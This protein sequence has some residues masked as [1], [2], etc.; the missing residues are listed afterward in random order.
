MEYTISRRVMVTY[1]RAP[2]IWWYSEGSIKRSPSNF[3]IFDPEMQ[4]AL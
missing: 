3:D 1:W 2:T 4:G